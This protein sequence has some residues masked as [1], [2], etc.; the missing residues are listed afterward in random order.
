M[1]RRALALAALGCACSRGP[2]PD[3]APSAP[4]PP[5][6]SAAALIAPVLASVHAKIS[7]AAPPWQ[8]EPLAFGS[9]LFAALGPAEVRVFTLPEGSLAFEAALEGPRGVVGIAMGS[10]VV[11]GA[12]RALRIDP[13]AKR[14][15]VLPPIPFLPGTLLLPERRDQGFVWA[16]QSAARLL[17]KQRLVPDPLRTFEA[18]VTLEGYD[19]GPITV[20]RDGTMLYRSPGGVTHALPEGRPHP[21]KTPFEVWR[22]LPGRRVDQAWA[23]AP[24]G[25]VEL[26]L[27]GEAGLPVQKRFAA[28]A[29]P[30]DAAASSAY[31]ALVLVDEPGDRPRSFRLAVFDN[32]GQKVLERPLP[33]GPVEAGEDWEVR[34]TENRH[35][36]L[37]ETEPFVAVGG[38][39]GFEVLELPGGRRV[40][41]R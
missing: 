41:G 17:V 19:G 4:P 16:V 2:A 35:V 28:G 11:A 15:V 23:V 10:L 36:A 9:H 20:L 32:D 30:F 24:D 8:L 34:A 14:P 6:A 22:L 29:A 21:L 7:L 1:H 26:W 25:R 33:P 27:V 18:G 38:P 40:L 3:A 5:S 13:H 39:G 37:G 12:E 31:L